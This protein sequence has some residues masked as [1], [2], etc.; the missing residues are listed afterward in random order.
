MSTKIIIIG[1]GPGGLATAMRLRAKGYSVTIYEA[2]DRVG[3][4]MRGFSDGAYHF[5][6]GPSIL[7]VPRVYD[8]L[9]AEAGLR[10][11]DYIRFK[12]VLPNTRIKFWDDTHLDLTSDIGDFKRQLGAIRA[13]LPAAFDRWYIDGPRA[14]APSA[15]MCR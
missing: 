10:R 6:T 2:A 1:A 12:Q 13:D 5:D 9:F 15:L 11:E 7:Q 4:R 14:S 3:G 8:E